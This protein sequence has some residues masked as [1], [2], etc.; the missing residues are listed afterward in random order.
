ME[1]D[2]GDDEDEEDCLDEMCASGP[3]VGSYTLTTAS[4]DLGKGPHAACRHPEVSRD[5]ATEKPRLIDEDQ[6]GQRF[7]MGLGRF[8]LP[9]S[10]LSGVGGDRRIPAGRWDFR[11]L[12]RGSRVSGGVDVGVWRG[13]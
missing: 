2:P 7:F 9:T 6:A 1:E 8:E 10:R 3:D 4:Q 12:R 11:G 5:F 13:Q